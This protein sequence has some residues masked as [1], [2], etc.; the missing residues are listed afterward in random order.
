MSIRQNPMRILPLV[1]RS[2]M[3][4]LRT[5]IPAKVL[6]Y[7]PSKQTAKCEVLVKTRVVNGETEEVTFETPPP[8]PDVP[9]IWPSGGGQSLVLGLEPGDPVFLMCADRSTDEWSAS[10]QD[11]PQEPFDVRQFD[12]SDAFAMPGGHSPSRSLSS[13]HYASGEA[14]LKTDKFRIG[15][16]TASQALALAEAVQSRLNNL[17]QLFNVHNH[18]SNAPGTPSGPPILPLTLIPPGEFDSNVA[19]TNDGF[20]PDLPDI[21]PMPDTPPPPEEE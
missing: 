17:I 15:D 12:L 21:P 7:D 4:R 9:V 5:A 19:Y 8:V 1:I 13:A 20:T 10:S 18:I 3:A 2:E 6:S 16:S 14:V 11:R